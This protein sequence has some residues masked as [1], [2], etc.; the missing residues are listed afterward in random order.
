LAAQLRLL[1]PALEAANPLCSQVIA[2]FVIDLQGLS[3]DQLA[4]PSPAMCLEKF[5]MNWARFSTFI[6]RPSSPGTLFPARFP[7]PQR[8]ALEFL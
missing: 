6:C 5:R 1:K 7:Q 3:Q 4:A 2:A 8:A